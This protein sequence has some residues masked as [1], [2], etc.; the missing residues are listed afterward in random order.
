MR[1]KISNTTRNL[2]VDRQGVKCARCHEPL[3]LS[4][5]H[6]DHIIPRAEGG[7][8]DSENYQALCGSC[9]N[10]KSQE[11]RFRQQHK[12][13]QTKAETEEESNWLI[14]FNEDMLPDMSKENIWNTKGL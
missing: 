3:L 5:T 1:E 6:I 12:N 4:D 7:P 13:K 8:K 14:P 11:D 9:H 2:V 10:I